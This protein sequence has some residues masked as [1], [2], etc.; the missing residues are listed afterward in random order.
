MILKRDDTALQFGKNI[1]YHYSEN[2]FESRKMH[3]GSIKSDEKLSIY[4]L[5]SDHCS[6]WA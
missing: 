1:K 3:V 4:A 2:G 5:S 6:P